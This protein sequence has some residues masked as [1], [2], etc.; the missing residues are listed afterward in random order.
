MS[1]ERSADWISAPIRIALSD[2]AAT[3][4]KAFQSSRGEAT[5]YVAVGPQWL[6]DQWVRRSGDLN[7]IPLLN[8]AGARGELLDYSPASLAIR[9]FRHVCG[10]LPLTSF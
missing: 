6:P 4:Q 8:G 2:P 3:T 5:R 1:G 10:P 7:P 9:R